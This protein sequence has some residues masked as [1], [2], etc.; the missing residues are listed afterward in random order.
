M[1]LHRERGDWSWLAEIS[2]IGLPA[3]M[4]K[5]LKHWQVVGACDGYLNGPDIR[6]GS[7]RDRVGEDQPQVLIG[8]QHG[9]E[10]AVISELVSGGLVPCSMG[11]YS[12]IRQF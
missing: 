1:V 9:A 6:I 2:A 12:E 5:H 8:R 11:K 3:Q 7:V 4:V 10:E